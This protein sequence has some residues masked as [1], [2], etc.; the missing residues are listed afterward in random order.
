MQ[1][2]ESYRLTPD[3]AGSIASAPHLAWMVQAVRNRRGSLDSEDRRSI[4]RVHAHQQHKRPIWLVRR[5]RLH[6][7]L[8]AHSNGRVVDPGARQMRSTDASARS[9]SSSATYSSRTRQGPHSGLKDLLAERTGVVVTSSTID[10]DT[11][12]RGVTP[13]G[14]Q[15][16][17]VR[18]SML[19]SSKLPLYRPLATPRVRHVTWSM[20]RAS[21]R[22][23]LRRVHRQAQQSRGLSAD[24]GR[25]QI[26]DSL[27]A[28]RN[29]PP[30]GTRP[31]ND[32]RAGDRAQSL[33]LDSWPGQSPATT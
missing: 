28:R 8:R 17:M 27:S 3:R 6:S 11:V 10:R 30:A 23:A 16:M 18:G 29:D 14:S 7:S 5:E 24:A 25:H 2:I 33:L 13:T 20:A 12:M 4:R 31:R 1:M 15:Q 9:H 26:Q 22:H 32:R 19:V 21:S